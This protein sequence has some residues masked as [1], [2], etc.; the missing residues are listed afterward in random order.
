MTS[1]PQLDIPWIPSGLVRFHPDVPPQVT[2]LFARC[3][4]SAATSTAKVPRVMPI[5]ALAEEPD[6]GSPIVALFDGKITAAH[7]PLLRGPRPPL[8]LACRQ[9]AEPTEWEVRAVAVLF[10]TAPLTAIAPVPSLAW[11][12]GG[13]ADLRAV[14]QEAG[15]CVRQAGAGA[16][17]AEIVTDVMYE[18]AANAFFD[19]PH[20]D[21]GVAK[22]AHR[23]GLEVE[24]DPSDACRTSLAVAGGRA[25]L[26]AIDRFGRLTSAPI[27]AVVAGLGAKAQ[28][29][30]AGGGAGLGLRRLLEH[31]DLWAVRITPTVV[32]EVLCVVDLRDTRRRGGNPKSLMF[33]SLAGR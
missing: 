27:A 4:L 18:L 2:A 26:S 23:R 8:L 28:V 32:T 33:S 6:D 21:E 20:T 10:A 30:L 13:A 16:S 29:N 19:A 1:I 25:Y 22:Y 11:R 12:I 14:S 5:G 17:A 3:G 31:S 7:A 24:F 9:T 15:L